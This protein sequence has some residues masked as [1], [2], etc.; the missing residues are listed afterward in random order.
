M[1]VRGVG[2]HYTEDPVLFGRAFSRAPTLSFSVVSGSDTQVLPSVGLAN[3]QG[4]PNCRGLGWTSN[5]GPYQVIADPF[6]EHQGQ[7]NQIVTSTVI[8]TA[9][10]V[11]WGD[12]QTI[13]TLW[14]SSV[15]AGVDWPREPD[16]ANLW[17][18]GTERRGSW[19]LST[20][21]SFIPEGS[22]ASNDWSAKC[23]LE[24]EESNVLIPLYSDESWFWDWAAPTSGTWDVESIVSVYQAVPVGYT[25]PVERYTWSAEPPAMAGWDGYASVFADAVGVLR[26]RAVNWLAVS[27]GMSFVDYETVPLRDDPSG[28]YS[29][30]VRYANDLV[31]D[32]VVEAN[33]WNT[34]DVSL[35]MVNPDRALTN[36]PNTVPEDQGPSNWRFEY[37]FVGSP[38]TTVYLDNLHMW[39][40]IVNSRPTF[41]TIGVEKW[42]ID[43]A[44]AYIGA[45][46]WFK[47]EA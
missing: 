44:G 30:Y 37:S 33:R 4:G 14:N 13:R 26:V 9:S 22:K 31:Q 41:M 47:V 2:E 36:F 34:F 45:Y 46:L 38:G 18:Q 3:W 12:S 8:P 23:V 20:D 7:F 10:T 24:E 32:F 29:T 40:R 15:G 17:C 25:D 11:V 43:E 39:N 42:L 28:H 6:F 19:S 5:L 27:G 21:Q 16:M 1:L 35:P